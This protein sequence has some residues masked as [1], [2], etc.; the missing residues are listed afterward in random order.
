MEQAFSTLSNTADYLAMIISLWLGFYLLS[1]ASKNQLVYRMVVCLF[2]LSLYYFVAFSTSWVTVMV[3]GNLRGAS[4]TTALITLHNLTHHLLASERRKTL[5]GLARS[6]LVLGVVTVGVFAGSPAVSSS[7]LEMMT[8]PTI[9]ILWFPAIFDGLVCAAVLY[10]IWR[11]VRDQTYFLNRA[12]YAA[13]GFGVAMAIYGVAE[14]IFRADL[15]RFVATFFVLLGLLLLGYSV[16]RYQALVVRR[17]TYLDLLVGLGLSMLTLGSSLLVARFLG[18]GDYEIGLF[19]LF[20]VLAYSIQDYTREYLVARARQQEVALRSEIRALARTDDNTASNRGTFRRALAILCHSLDAES[21]MILL[22]E[23][24]HFAVNASYHAFP[25]GSQLILDDLP[26]ETSPA[27]SWP[28]VSSL[29]W[30]V[31]IFSGNDLAGLVGIG[32]RTGLKEYTEDDIDWMEEVSESIGIIL[33]TGQTGGGPDYESLRV[34]DKPSYDESAEVQDIL[35][36]LALKPGPEIIKMVEDGFRMLHDYSNLGKSPLV[37]L[38][39]VSRG[40]HIE[41]GRQVHQHLLETLELLRP[42]ESRPAEPIPRTWHNYLVLRDAYMHRVS[43]SEIMARLYISSGTYYR[44]RRKALRS[45][46]RALIE[47]SA[48]QE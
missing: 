15:P 23:Q 14:F 19:G 6:I 30:I 28:P 16:A 45:I 27:S 31:P 10:N 24:E 43:T 17:T 41:A 11:I 40:S 25:L 36:T 18:L 46:S 12:I 44:T 21:G 29:E 8:T 9:T 1:R 7:S 4:V 48:S 5:D 13:F 20:S 26:K 37:E 32:P 39:K 33:Q 2:A 42:E 22:R 35:S 38:L 47:R 3:G 34:Q